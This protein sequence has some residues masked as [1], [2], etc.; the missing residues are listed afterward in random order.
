MA[1]AKV[2]VWVFT[3]G[4]GGS[5]YSLALEMLFIIRQV[6]LWFFEYPGDYELSWLLRKI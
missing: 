1:K 2:D 5:R 6:L 3:V 4:V